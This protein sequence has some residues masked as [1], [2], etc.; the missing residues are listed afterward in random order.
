MLESCRRQSCRH[1]PS[2][3]ALRDA[4]L[5][6]MPRAPGT[7]LRPC[8]GD[9]D[10][11]TTPYPWRSPPPAE[12]KARGRGFSGL[13]RY[14]AG[15]LELSPFT[16]H[17]TYPCQTKKFGAAGCTFGFPAYPSCRPDTR[18]CQVPRVNETDISAIAETMAHSVFQIVKEL[19][20]AE[21]WQPGG[22]RHK[23]KN[24]GG[25]CRHQPGFCGNPREV[26]DV[27]NLPEIIWGDYRISFPAKLS[28]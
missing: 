17:T 2:K 20:A 16:V 8:L 18:L 5:C 10:Q 26:P 3:N 13:T 1:S 15:Y 22:Q 6:A 24:P 7:A 27:G 21:S 12:L 19:R 28:A 9:S 11:S 25:A 14:R 23:R 4:G